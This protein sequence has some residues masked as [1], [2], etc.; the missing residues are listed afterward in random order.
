[1]WLCVLSRTAYVYVC[2]VVI[3]LCGP[4]NMVG[5]GE[6]DEDLQPEVQEECG[7]YGQVSKCLIFEVFAH[8]DLDMT[9]SR[10]THNGCLFQRVSHCVLHSRLYRINDLQLSFELIFDYHH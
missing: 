8:T 3:C 5:P 7:K 1:M 6:V 9:E 4:Q 10:V 2:T